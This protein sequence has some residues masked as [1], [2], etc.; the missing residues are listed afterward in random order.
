MKEDLIKTIAR[1]KPLQIFFK[2][3]GVTIFITGFLGIYAFLIMR[4]NTLVQTEP[5]TV[6]LD[7]RL[8]DIK[9]TKINKSAIDNIERLKDQNIEVKSLFEHARDNPFNE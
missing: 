7:N 5:T 8:K 3:Y 4:V 2:R 6:Q 9:R 1:L